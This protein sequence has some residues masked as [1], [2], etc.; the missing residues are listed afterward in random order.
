MR[1][2]LRRRSI[3]QPLGASAQRRHPRDN[4]ALPPDIIYLDL[5]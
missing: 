3:P 5:I 4:L 1:L 2:P